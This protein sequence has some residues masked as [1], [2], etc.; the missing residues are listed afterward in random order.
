MGL[1]VLSAL[2]HGT[3]MVPARKVQ[4]MRT[5]YPIAPHQ[6]ALLTRQMF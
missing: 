2:L 1:G 5:V 6:R 3:D 4:Q